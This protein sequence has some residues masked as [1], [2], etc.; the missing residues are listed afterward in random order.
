MNVDA[1]P[2]LRF[3]RRLA[4]TIS[5]A[6]LSRQYFLGQFRIKTW[7]EHFRIELPGFHKSG[8]ADLFAA[9]SPHIET[10]EKIVRWVKSERLRVTGRRHSVGVGSHNKAVQRL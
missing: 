8:V 6:R 10:P 3:R 7:P 2:R 1:A 5:G 4:P 9:Q